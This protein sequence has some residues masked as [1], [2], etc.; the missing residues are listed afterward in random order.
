LIR[1]FNT[2]DLTLSDVSDVPFAN[3]PFVTV[4]S[5]NGG[6]TYTG[7]NNLNITWTKSSCISQWATW[8]ISLSTDN[9]ATWSTIGSPSNTANTTTQSFNYSIPAG[10]ASTQ[11]K[12]RVSYSGQND[13]SDNVFVIIPNNDITITNPIGG[14]TYNA[15]NMQTVS[16]INTP[17][18]SGIYDI[19]FSASGFGTTLVGNDIIGNSH[20]WNVPNYPTTTGTIEVRDASTSCKNDIN[21]PITVIAATPV[22]TAPNGGEQW[23]AGTSSTITWNTATVY[24]SDVRLD[25]SID[26]G[27]TW[28]NIVSSTP[29]DGS[30]N[31]TVPNTP[32]SVALVRISIP[33]NLSYF[34]VSNAVFT[35]KPAIQIIT[36]NGDDGVTEWGGC[37]VTSITFEHSPAY[38]SFNIQYSTNGGNTWINI[39]TNWSAI[40]N[41]ATYNWTMPNVNNLATL[42]RVTSASVSDQSDAPFVIQKPVTLIQ[43]NFG[44]IL[45]VGSNYEVQW[46]SDGISNIYDL[47]YSTNG[48]TSYTSIVNGYVTS[49]N[50]YNW[51]VPA[52]PSSNCRMVIRD[53]INTCKADTSDVAF[54]IST[55]A[56]PITILTPNGNANILQGCQTY[57]ID[58]VETSAIA[59]YTIEYSLNSGLSWT[60]IVTDYTTANSQYN[61][62]VPNINSNSVLIRVRSTSNPNIFDLSDAFFSIEAGELEVSASTT[63]ICEGQTVQLNVEGGSG[64]SWSP[65]S[66]LNIST[67]ANPIASPSATTVYT[68]SSTA[69]G[70][71]MSASIEINVAPAS[72]A[73]AVTISSSNNG[74]PVCTGTPV[75]FTAYGSDGGNEPEYQWYINNLP[76]GTNSSVFSL[77]SV[78]DGDQISVRL[79]SSLDCVSNNPAYSNTITMEASSLV[80]PTISIA[81][82]ANNSPCNGTSQSFTAQITNGGT[83]PSYA[84]YLNDEP[85]LGNQSNVTFLNMQDGDVIRVVLTSNSACASQSTV[86][87]AL[88]VVELSE[89]PATPTQI[90]GSNTFCVGD[91][92]TYT[93]TTVTDA[94]SYQWTLPTG[95]LGSSTGTSIDVTAGNN[96]GNIQVTSSNACGT[97]MPVTLSLDL[98]DTPSAP[99]LVNGTPAFCSNSTNTYTTPSV[100]GATSYTWIIPSGWIGSSTTSSIDVIA[101]STGGSIGVAAINGCGVSAFTSI[102]VNP[103][104]ELS[105][106]SLETIPAVCPGDQMQVTADYSGDVMSFD[107]NLPS[108][109]VGTSSEAAI[110]LIAGNTDGVISVTAIG[111]CNELTAVATVD[112]LPLPQQP[113]LIDGPTGY[114]SGEQLN[115]SITSVPGATSYTW[116]LPNDWSGA[117]NGP[118]IAVVSGSLQGIISVAAVNGCGAGLPQELVVEPNVTIAAPN[119]INGSATVCI[120]ASEM[121]STT[122]VAGA[123][124][125]IW[126]LP[127]GWQ[128]SSTGTSINATAGL[129]GGTVSVY[130]IGA[131]GS[132]VATTLEIDLLQAPAQPEVIEETVH[133]CPGENHI[134]AV[135]QIAG[136]SYTWLLPSG[137]NGS[138]NASQIAVTAGTQEGEA[139][140]TANNTCGTSIPSSI[141]LVANAAPTS[142]SSI[143]GPT[144]L[145]GAGTYTYTIDTA[146]LADGYTWNA[147]NGWIIDNNGTSADITVNSGSGIISVYAYNGC[148]ST[149]VTTISVDIESINNGIQQDGNTLIAQA[150]GMDYQWINCITSQEI[151]GATSQSYDFTMNGT[152]AVEISSANCSTT[153]DC[154]SV[155]FVGTEELDATSIA[156]YPNPAREYIQ[157]NVNSQQVGTNY[158]V[159]DLT[160]RIAQRGIINNT[161]TR[162]ELE[163]LS[164][165]MYVLEIDAM[166]R[167]EFVVAK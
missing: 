135:E 167:H 66:S 147:P 106:L 129:D 118:S 30:H 91:Q 122:A 20:T 54:T 153:S 37:T 39:V 42:V 43:P 158:V 45:Q 101:S 131:C 166:Y 32:T 24:S 88:Y 160:G 127:S 49:T 103:A 53:N 87:S 130:A 3:I 136:I 98:G 26:E 60:T 70:C 114:C 128:G 28:I 132:S 50:T 68:V 5:P 100:L 85:A 145:C 61:W 77:P 73:A 151:Q 12:V 102:T 55:S 51:T 64:Y 8:T 94:T 161:T 113:N 35:I 97:S 96:S 44:G 9:G 65:A 15:F 40:P 76:V 59:T 140:V 63:N 92:L 16:W 108:G 165:G 157:F 164:S 125:Y 146:P 138:G 19:Y 107:W 41:P 11:C 104:A 117:S 115:Y 134:L 119:N 159:Y 124:N 84:W 123:L 31:W 18:T 121:Y 82:S 139:L 137:W 46:S 163:S 21:G 126:E 7:C 67:I 6:A 110:A 86:E 38:T 112:V 143:D 23:Y 93:A 81:P 95:W 149:D 155:V 22:L 36:P 89:G 111:A 74:A 152:Y 142:I 148:G 25:Y 2:G 57:L 120:G 80:L 62:V 133:F 17:N 83:I 14:E 4:T 47:Y 58:W 48:G 56:A 150:P 116:T 99:S 109:F 78:N 156:L 162:I 72:Y 141:E 27:L 79:T 10:T 52:I 33:T 29:N 90:V 13:E 144:Q 34:D 154:I 71:T 75:T 105:E 1:I 69:L